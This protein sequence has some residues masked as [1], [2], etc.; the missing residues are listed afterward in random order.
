M[1]DQSAFD[2]LRDRKFDWRSATI[3]GMIGIL[4]PYAGAVLDG[5]PALG[6]Q[7]QQMIPGVS[8]D[9]TLA[10]PWVKKNGQEAADQYQHISPE[11][12]AK[13]TPEQ[14]AK[15]NQGNA[16][17][18]KMRPNYP[19]NEVY[20]KYKDKGKWKE[21]MVDSYDPDKGEII[22][23]KHTQL[24]EIQYQSAKR[25]MDEFLMKYAPGTRIRDVP[26]Q[27]KGSGHQNAGLAGDTL[28]G[29]MILEVPVQKKPVPRNV[30]EYATDND[31]IIRDE[32]G[33]VYNP[34]VLE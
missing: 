16:F 8:G 26:T 22:S 18:E 2:W 17:N 13:M 19:H 6:K 5:A 3:A 29:D 14:K 30:R 12:W 4:I 27:R 7:L 32:K 28:K 24:A 25:Y 15:V 10:M 20:V 31:I 1:A 23:R 9:G 21:G 34:E 33:K 11:D